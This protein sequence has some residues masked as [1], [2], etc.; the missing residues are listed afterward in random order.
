MY[1]RKNNDNHNDRI[2][3]KDHANDYY[4]NHLPKL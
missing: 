2:S 3:I 4:F 1:E